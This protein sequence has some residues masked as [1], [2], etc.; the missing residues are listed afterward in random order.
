MEKK[1]KNNILSA[2]IFVLSVVVACIFYVVV[3]QRHESLW[4]FSAV[5]YLCMITFI[6]GFGIFVSAIVLE[7]NIDANNN[8]NN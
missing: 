8:E 2:I 5:F 4:E 6:A 7:K 1:K 3:M